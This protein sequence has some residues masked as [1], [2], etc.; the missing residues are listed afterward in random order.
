M[1][2]YRL[3]LLFESVRGA[4]YE[5]GA[6]WPLGAPPEDVRTRAVDCSGFIRWLIH[7]AGGPELPHG[8]YNQWQYVRDVLQ[9]R[10]VNY[11]DLRYTVQD[12]GRAFIAFKAP[13]R[14]RHGHVWVVYRGATMESYAKGGVWSRGY[15]QLARSASACYEIPCER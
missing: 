7:A 5:L 6:K 3:W 14:K 10:P 9:W 13:G 2:P 8:S 15:A 4:P 11:A 1:S 12:G